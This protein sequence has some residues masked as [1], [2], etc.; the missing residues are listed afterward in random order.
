MDSPVVSV[1][2]PTFNSAT[3]LH[4][5]VSSVLEQSM[6]KF[7]LIIC[8]DAS[9]DNTAELLNKITDPRVRLIKNT[10]NLGPG[11]SRDKAINIAR[12][13]WVAFIDADDQWRPERLSILIEAAAD[14]K[15]DLIFDDILLCHDTDRGLVPWRRVYGIKQFGNRRE[16]TSIMASAVS[17]QQYICSRRLLI[18]PVIRLGFIRRNNISHSSIRFAEDAEYILRLAYFDACFFYVPK[19]MYLYRIASGSLTA[20]AKDHTL[21]R[22]VVRECSQWPSWPLNLHDAFVFKCGELYKDEQIYAFKKAIES[23]D[24]KK[25][26]RLVIANPLLVFRAVKYIP[27][28]IYYQLH[29]IYYKGDKR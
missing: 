28:Q 5:A 20:Q 2:L 11:I 15:A 3:T 8:D 9:T 19:A 10:S 13:E 27:S 18:K 14:V 16:K 21:M 22:Q 26:I 23:R 6:C 7:E 24:I 4:A 17:H 29:R 12:G 1:I 25:A